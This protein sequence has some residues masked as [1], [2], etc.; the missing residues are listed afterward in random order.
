MIRILQS[1]GPTLKIILGALLVIICASM[2]ITLIP[3][4]GSNLGIGTPARGVLARIGDQDVTVSEV[5]REAKAMIRQQFPRG[6]AQAAMLMPYFAGQAAEQLI[7]KKAVV[8]EAHRIG[9]RVSDDELR[10][11]FE[12]GQYASVFFPDGKFIGQ[13]EYE[14]L[15]QRADLTIPQFEEQEKERILIRK[16]QALVSSSAFV[17]D[18]EVRDEF[19]RRNTKVKFEYAVLTR[20]S[21]TAIRRTITIRFQRSGRSSTSSSTHPKWGLRPA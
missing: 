2:V 4:S 1:A 19:E 11:E 8:A 12:H 3:G 5:Q 17:G 13:G 18:A 16:L 7:N 14:N 6:G 10:D 21:T 15:L 20:R 9:L